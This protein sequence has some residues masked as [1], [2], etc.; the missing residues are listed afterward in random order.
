[1]E[2]TLKHAISSDDRLALLN[3]TSSYGI[4]APASSG[5]GAAC[6]ANVASKLVV[7][8]EDVVGALYNRHLPGTATA[9]S[10][11]ASYKP[12]DSNRKHRVN[13]MK[14]QPECL[15]SP[16]E[17]RLVRTKK[18]LIQQSVDLFNQSPSKSIQFLKDNSIF[19][20][21]PNILIKQLIRYLKETPTL[22]KKVSCIIS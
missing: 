13:R 9:A 14:V 6:A 21:E 1:M 10:A 22:D 18:G 2:S 11:A 12:R 20:N 5:Y 17:L 4:R 8:E 15:P 3:H 7:G 16:D 19:S